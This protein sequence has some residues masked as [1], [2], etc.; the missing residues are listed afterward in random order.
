MKDYHDLYLKCDVFGKLKLRF[1]KLADIF[2][3]FKYDSLKNG[4]CPIHYLSS[5]ALSRKAILNMTKIE[6]DF[7]LDLN[8]YLSFEKGMRGADSYA[9]NK[10]S[11][12]NNK[13]LKS[14]DQKQESK[15][16]IYLDANNLYCKAMSTFLSTS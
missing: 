1:L 5:L 6:L 15:H 13:Y 4:L 16:I 7:I 14:Y 2:G 10:Y 3:K 12:A 11:K 9:P 8:M